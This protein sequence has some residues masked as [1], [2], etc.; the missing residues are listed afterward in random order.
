MAIQR[1]REYSLSLYKMRINFYIG[2]II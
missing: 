2:T 1:L